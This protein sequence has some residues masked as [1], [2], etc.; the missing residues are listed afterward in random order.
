M[1]RGTSPE[2]LILLRR[3]V[4]VRTIATARCVDRS[5]CGKNEMHYV[6]CKPSTKQMSIQAACCMH[7]FSCELRMH[8]SDLEQQCQVCGV[9]SVNSQT[10]TLDL[11]P[12][13][14][15]VWNIL[16]GVAQHARSN[17]QARVQLFRR[18]RMPSLRSWGSPRGWW[19]LRAAARCLA[20][21]CNTCRDAS[22][23]HTSAGV[24][25]QDIGKFV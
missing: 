24:K 12:C 19:D 14:S 22:V 23:M 6:A 17:Y 13:N 16:C 18:L 4:N 11:R 8:S 20:D 10:C 25:V 7:T 5:G 9:R 15:F 2:R 21:S 3:E 1:E